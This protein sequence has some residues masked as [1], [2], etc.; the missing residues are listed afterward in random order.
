[1]FRSLPALQPVTGRNWRHAV[2]QSPLHET[3]RS[4]NSHNGRYSRHDGDTIS[5]RYDSTVRVRFFPRSKHPVFCNQMNVNK[6]KTCVLSKLS[7]K[8]SK[9]KKI[10]REDQP[11]GFPSSWV[12][13]SNACSKS[14]VSFYGELI[15]SHF[16]GS[17][18]SKYGKRVLCVM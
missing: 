13:R 8:W 11:R 17:L 4:S 12:T 7:K 9:Q 16:G 6:P 5:L 1:M 3:D 14:A 2:T 18:I 15:T 10:T